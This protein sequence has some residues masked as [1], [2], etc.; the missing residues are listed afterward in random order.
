MPPTSRRSVLK[1]KNVCVECKLEV[2]EDEESI[3]CDKCNNSFHVVCTKLNKKQFRHLLAHE[4][5]EFVC[6]VC[7][8]SSKSNNNNS[9]GSVAA[10][11]NAM[12]MELKKLDELREMRETMM[13]MSKQYDDILKGVS[14]NKKK[15]DLV[16]KENK[17]LRAEVSTLKETVKFLNNQ[18]VQNDCLITGIKPTENE[19]A[20][21]AV[22]KLSSKFG[23]E[24][25]V[26][27][28]SDA[29]FLNKKK[30]D[31]QT[32]VV[33][34]NSRIAKSKLMAVKPKLK[35]QEESKNIFVSDFSSKETM[36][37]FKYAK[38]LKNVGFRAIYTANNKVF[39][40]R[41]EL[42]KPRLLKNED[43]VDKL[44]AE[45]TTHQP[46]KRRSQQMMIRVE[47]SDNE[48]ESPS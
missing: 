25:K 17:E 3:D 15:I 45:A 24:M 44:L 28:I 9:N 29:Y 47:E 26:D 11:L 27:N 1:K 13:F 10:E 4:D 18:R 12:R 32:V 20:V 48:Y 21:D 46:Q 5:E 31:S 36:N 19:T 14:E 34:F 30:N 8:S 37:L 16:Q 6:H 43:E 41:S 22:M 42:S 33:K 2:D 40:K 39:A 35:A 38:S 7:D 23:V